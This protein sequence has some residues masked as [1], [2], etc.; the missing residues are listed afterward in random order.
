M[1]T[2]QLEANITELMDRDAI[3]DGLYRYCRGIDRADEAALRGA[4]WPDAVDNH[5]FYNGPIEGFIDR[6]KAVWARKPR[7]IHAVSNILIEFQSDSIAHVESYFTAL[8]RGAGDDKVVHQ[9][10]LSGRYCDVFEKRGD[11]WRVSERTVVYDW[12]EEQSVPEAS[13]EDRF[14]PRQPIGADY[15]DD[16]VYQMGKSDR[17]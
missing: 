14:G 11:E 10:A 13:E 12:V 2:S 4:Y 9:F 8:Q 15:P 6:V 17:S 3:R 16:P 7:N 1:K 5:G